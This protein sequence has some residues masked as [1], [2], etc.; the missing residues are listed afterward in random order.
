MEHPLIQEAVIRRPVVRELLAMAPDDYA[1]VRDLWKAHSKAEDARDIPGLMA[2]LTDD[3]VYELVQSGHRWEGHEGA[4]RFYTELLT[5][6]P[7]IEFSLTNIFIGP[8][9]VCEEAV[10]VG[11][12]LGTW[13]GIEPTGERMVWRNV[14]FFP[15]DPDRRL[16][17]GERVY[18]FF[19]GL[20]GPENPFA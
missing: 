2:T 12:H 14:I 5:A 1:E 18:T 13:L 6:F 20:S 8:Q 15:W 19:P 17:T 7:D 11:T 4:T 9:G 10:V 3:C 16:F